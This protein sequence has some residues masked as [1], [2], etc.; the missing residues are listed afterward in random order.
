MR[1]ASSFFS[2]RSSTK[3][4]RGDPANTFG[5]TG[6]FCGATIV[7][8]AT[9]LEYRTLMAASPWPSTLTL[10]SAS[11]L[12]TS[13]SLL[14]NLAQWVT[15]ALWPSAYQARTTICSASLGLSTAAAGNTSSRW[16]AGSLALGPGAPEAIQSA[17]IW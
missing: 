3:L 6:V 14:E 15:S 11:T 1:S 10:P 9:R 8:A 4:C 16:M 7:V 5:S 17:K 13:S 2:T 12:A